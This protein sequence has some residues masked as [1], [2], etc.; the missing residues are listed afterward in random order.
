MFGLII[1]IT[2]F[3]SLIT[4]KYYTCLAPSLNIFH[5]ICEPHA[6]HSVHIY[7]FFSTQ[8]PEP[9]RKKKPQITWTQWK[10]K[11][12][13]EYPKTPEITEPKRRKEKRKWKKGRHWDDWTQEK[14]EKK[15]EDWLKV[16][17]EL[18][19]VGPLCVFNY[20]NVI[21]LWVMKTKNS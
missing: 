13:Q 5:T 19:L 2:Q 20:K 4:L 18:W 11:K 3:L 1:F 14:K 15:K 10:K 9:E 21:K 12:K 17:A 8:K 16:A 7:I 6:Y